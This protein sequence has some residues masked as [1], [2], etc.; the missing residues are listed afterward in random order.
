M[1][2]KE[3]IE[4]ACIQVIQ[5]HNTSYIELKNKWT[6]MYNQYENKARAGSITEE[7]ESPAY[8]GAAFSIVEQFTARMFARPPRYKYFAR[9]KGDT[10][11]TDIY[12]SF[13]QYQYEANKAD[14][15]LEE[16]GKWGAITGLSP[17][18]MVWK[19]KRSI[20]NT[21]TKT[22]LGFEV[23]N[24]ILQQYAT[25]TTKA[26]ESVYKNW[27]IKSIRPFD[28][29]WSVDAINPA[30]A[31]I[32][33]HLVEYTIA[34]LK[35]AGFDTKKIE[36]MIKDTED[37]WSE[38]MGEYNTLETRAAVE[39]E[40]LDQEKIKLYEL[41]VEMTNG[42]YLESH[43]AYIASHTA[44]GESS[45]K[46]IENPYDDKFCP[47]GAW[48]PI[49]RVGKYYG[50]GLIEPVEGV[51]NAEEDMFNL[52]KEATLL[53]TARP[54]EY[55]PTN[56]Y[57]LDA[58]EYKPRVLVPVRDLGNSVKTMDAPKPD[59][60]SIGYSLGYLG[61]VRQEI[62]AITDYQTGADKLGGDKTATEVQIKT[63]QSDQRSTKMLRS[64][65]QEVLVPM[66]TIALAMN[67]QYLADDKDIMFRI[68]GK[69]GSINEEKIRFSDIEAIKDISVVGGSSAYA[70]Q[71]E[72]YAKWANFLPVAGQL[73]QMGLQVNIEEVGRRM[74]EDGLQVKDS[75]N[76]IP[77]LKEVE[78]DDVQG[79]V[80][81]M[82]KAKEENANPL[83]ARVSPDDNHEIHMQLH[84]AQI[85]S[86]AKEDGSPMSPEEHQALV[87]H[88][89]DHNTNRG[90]VATN[91][92]I[93]EDEGEANQ[94]R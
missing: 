26:K 32:Q 66:G 89:E 91:Q 3:K 68:T 84:E 33:G 2:S 83:T 9:E 76:I 63:A 28:Y 51:I 43:V 8:L 17:W 53:N 22:I 44:A 54:M 58:L 60:N 85:K 48:R 35:D 18:K 27:E 78:E 73:M 34:E 50:F 39:A 94:N 23:T 12:N 55:N 62:T 38:K 40:L 52:A 82:N 56:I 74:V 6:S 15:E 81:Q 7:C 79:K 65:E 25:T 80:A 42:E 70:L 57:N 21:R 72:E 20:K 69:K 19:E 16:I 5:D 90:G 41:F 45:L 13:S 67:K 10:K 75:E 37:Y 11:A 88:Y 49:K 30:E 71:Q 29:V 86:G 24:P 4:K 64:F 87:K 77:S 31:M 46:I 92:L 93:Q 36:G 59:F 14:E 61:K 47:M 1:L